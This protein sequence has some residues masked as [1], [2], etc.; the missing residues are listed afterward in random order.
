[1]TQESLVWMVQSAREMRGDKEKS[2]ILRNLINRASELKPESLVLMLQ[3]VG[4]IRGDREKLE[5]MRRLVERYSEDPP[6]RSAWFEALVQVR[7]E[8]GRKELL[9]QMLHRASLQEATL[10]EII[11]M[12]REMRS[13][14]DKLELMNELAVRGLPPTLQTSL[15]DAL[16]GAGG[17]QEQQQEDLL[18]YMAGHEPAQEGLL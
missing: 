1:M 9:S 12:T 16:Q 15:M 7:S 4:E 8:Q 5:V 11:R 13:G 10:A 2:E 14:K 17:M 3:A 6:V 18:T